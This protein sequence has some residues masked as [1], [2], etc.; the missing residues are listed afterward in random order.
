MWGKLLLGT[1]PVSAHVRKLSTTTDNP[2]HNKKQENSP[3]F[4][5]SEQCKV[6]S[7]SEMKNIDK[8]NQNPALRYN[9]KSNL[10]FNSI[11]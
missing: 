11:S 9:P 5:S 2:R 3:T 8:N 7:N 1:Y 10:A 4:V 6:A